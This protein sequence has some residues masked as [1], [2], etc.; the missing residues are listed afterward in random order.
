MS[1]QILVRSTFSFLDRTY[2]LRDNHS[3]INDLTILYFRRM[4]FPS[5]DVAYSYSTGKKLILAMCELIENDRRGNEFDALLLKG[6]LRMLYVLGV[7][8]RRFEPMFLE[9]SDPFFRE[10]AASRST[11]G[12]KGYIQACEK[13]LQKEHDRCL[14][15]NIDSATERQLMDSAHDTLIDD[16]TDKLLDVES[17][18]KLLASKDVESMKGL[19]DLLCLSKIQKKLREPWARYIETACSEIISDKELGDT[20]VFRLLALRR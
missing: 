15:F 11:S 8:E 14:E 9:E 18:G 10:F 2:L 20:M 16:Y 19:Y 13:L 17:L 3:S 1:V 5:Q 4:A 7:Y 12:L 6:S